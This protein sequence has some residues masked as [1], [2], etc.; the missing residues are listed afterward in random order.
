MGGGG[1][2]TGA[3]WTKRVTPACV[4]AVEWVTHARV[5]SVGRSTP[6]RGPSNTP[7]PRR[8]DG[9]GGGGGGDAEL[10]AP[11]G[12]AAAG[13]D[14]EC[15]AGLVAEGATEG[16]GAVREVVVP[17]AVEAARHRRRRCRAGRRPLH[18]GAPGKGGWDPSSAPTRTREK[19]KPL[20]TNGGGLIG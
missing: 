16:E 8:S 18:R 14:V 4:T 1:R 17:A 20:A 9:S 2:T 12:G 13:A 15:V 19:L 10:E 7:P 5:T 11:L 3:R 6:L